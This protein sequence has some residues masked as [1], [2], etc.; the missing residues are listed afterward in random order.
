[1]GGGIVGGGRVGR[2]GRGRCGEVWRARTRGGGWVWAGIGPDC[3]GIAL[4]H[5][6]S[7]ISI[8]SSGIWPSPTTDLRYRVGNSVQFSDRF[9][10][11]KKNTF[12]ME[13]LDFKS[14]FEITLPRNPK[15]KSKIPFSNRK[16]DFQIDFLYRSNRGSIFQIDF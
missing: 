3:K 9:S 10:A 15:T 8:S 5:A 13:S 11:P 2:C 14:I 6:E 16:S 12:Q 4:A 7:H 1:M